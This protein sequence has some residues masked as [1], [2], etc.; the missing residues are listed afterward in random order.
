[1]HPP[2]SPAR[3]NFTLI[4]ECTPESSGC[5]FVYS[6]VKPAAAAPSTKGWQPKGKPAGKDACNG[7]T[8]MAEAA[9]KAAEM[10]ADVGKNF[11][12]PLR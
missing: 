8:L 6:V 10:A 11:I 2:P 3:T 7:A 5:N 4:T 12:K 9:A 1:M